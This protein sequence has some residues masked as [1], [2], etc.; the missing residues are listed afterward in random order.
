MKQANDGFKMPSSNNISKR[1]HT[2][3]SKEELVSR[4]RILKSKLKLFDMEFAH[5][6]GRKPSKKEKEGI[7]GLFQEYIKIKAR[8]SALEKGKIQS[9]RTCPSPKTPNMSKH[10][11]GLEPKFLEW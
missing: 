7:A 1:L 9:P 8:L 5:N 6:H 3:S 2:S 10:L 11:K 4:K